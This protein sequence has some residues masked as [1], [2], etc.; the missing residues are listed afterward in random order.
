MS[1][2]RF[3]AIALAQN[4]ILRELNLPTSNVSQYFAENVFN[5]QMMQS[6]LNEEA[7]LQV[8]E[9]IREGRTIDRAMANQVAI[10]LK[11]WAMDKGA[12]HYTHWFQPLTGL[13]AEKK[14]TF[15]KP[16]L[17][18]KKIETFN[19]DRLIQGEPDGANFPSGGLR[20]THEARGYTAWDPTSP[21]FIVE[22]GSAGKTLYIPTIFISYSGASMDYKAPLL[23][24]LHFVEKAALDLV[25]MFD[26]NIQKVTT[27][28]GWEQEFF[29]IDEALYNARP[30]LMVSGRT[31]V[32]HGPAKGQQLDD[33]YFT[34]IPKRVHLFLQEVEYEAHRLGIPITTSHNEIAPGQFEICPTY[35]EANK[36]IDQNQLIMDLMQHIAKQHH[37]RVLFHE[38][39]FNGLNGSAKHNNWSLSTDTGINLLAPGRTPKK[40]LQFLTIFINM[41][42]AVNENADLLRTAVT[43][44][45]NDYRLG[46]NEAPP[47]ITSVFIGS[48]LTEVLK[49]LLDKVKK[50]K[51]DGY[52]KQ[53]LKVQLH[54][55]LPEVLLD[56]T[57]LNRTAPIAFTGNKFELRAVGSSMN[58]SFPVTIL[59]AIVGQQFIDFKNDVNELIQKGEKKD[60]A[61][62][63]VL[64]TYIQDSQRILFEGDTYSEE[65][66]KEAESRGLSNIASTT[67][68]L[69]FLKST[70]AKKAL[71]D[72]KIFRQQELDARYEVLQEQYQ[73]KLQIEARM[74]GQIASS[75][76]LPVAWEYC[77][78]L[79]ENV[80]G[81]EAIGFDKPEHSKTQKDLVNYI[82][83]RV[84]RIN[85]NVVEM[86]K[87]RKEVNQIEDISK[88]AKA[89]DNKVKPFFEKIRRDIDKL[90]LI[91]DDKLWPLPKYQE[92]LF[93][94]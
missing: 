5:D 34:S 25:N 94:R 24:S 10:G 15:F 26:R 92:L 82:L 73:M 1:I 81:L 45:G 29:L 75:M 46:G 39:P 12:K 31:L 22:M 71:I 78:K 8:K 47:P 64:R 70:A 27:T 14:E 90:E 79:I 50:G 30:D 80:K 32:G 72:S 84:H 57:D 41:L 40:N 65:W 76:I 87:T 67:Y 86:I 18:G 17:D 60:T 51:M 23:K 44:P 93:I 21:P 89:Y 88:K 38:K 28:L 36:S 54:D 2:E 56:N 49:D 37:F 62:F 42:K 68:A 19:G 53:D 63:H 83:E 9:V 77:N 74:L 66:K 91:I 4:R 58:C 85:D 59:N 7:Y 20:T 69:D 35:S 13:T 6:F 48:T 33:H 61:I 11:N 52:D 55:K 43:S 16:S 3:K